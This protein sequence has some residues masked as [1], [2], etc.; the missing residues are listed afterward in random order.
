M[1]DSGVGKNLTTR[2]KIDGVINIDLAVLARR[3]NHHMRKAHFNTLSS[4][5]RG[6]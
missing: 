3:R 6:V 4:S 5:Q 2:R 1:F